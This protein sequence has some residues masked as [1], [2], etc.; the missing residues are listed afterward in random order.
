MTSS[1]DDNAADEDNTWQSSKSSALD[2]AAVR[3]IVIFVLTWKI[4]HNLSDAAV[5]ALFC[6][7]KRILDL[8]ARLAQCK[9]L[10]QVSELLPRSLYMVRKYFGVNR[11]DFE[12]FIVCPKCSSCYK[13]ED[14][15]H[16]L[17]NGKKK[18]ARCTFVEFPHHPRKTQ[19]KPCRAS[20]L[21]AVRSKHEQLILK[22][23]RVF[24][25]RS[26]KKTLQEF[27]KRPGFSDKCEQ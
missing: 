12:K 21:K 10:K 5:S 11:D 16:T 24:C 6:F 3:L 27:L 8:L 13:P 17:S 26:V 18:G 7:L 9:T 2:K 22:A 19:R 23:K 1:D 14:C 20:L 15:A 25:Y 4:M